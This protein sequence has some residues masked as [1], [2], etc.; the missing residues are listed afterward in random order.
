MVSR[1]LASINIA[2]KRVGKCTRAPQMDSPQ[3][4]YVK[5]AYLIREFDSKTV[6]GLERRVAHE[7]SKI[8]R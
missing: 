2:S 5:S 7:R 6:K 8:I 3:L 1:L 4:S